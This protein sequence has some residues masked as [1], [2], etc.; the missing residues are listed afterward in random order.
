M[1]RILWFVAGA[2]VGAAGVFFYQVFGKPAEPA[3]PAEPAKPAKLAKLDEPTYD[4]WADI[5]DDWPLEWPP[6]PDETQPIKVR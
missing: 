5:F 2:V 1:K 4:G 3:E 6:D